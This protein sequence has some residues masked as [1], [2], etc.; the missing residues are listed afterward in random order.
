MKIDLAALFPFQEKAESY[1]VSYEGDFINGHRVTEAPEFSL[2]IT[3]HKDRMIEASGTGSV[4][5]LMQCSRCLTEVPWEIPFRIQRKADAET[6]LDDEGEEV[7]FFDDHTLDTDLLI[8]DE[9]LTDLP[10]KVLC[11]EDCKGICDR[12]GANLNLGPCGCS[13]EAAPTRMAEALQQAF[14]DAMKNA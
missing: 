8:A 9:V 5:L 3:H 2:L 6:C 4:T 14:R 7:W 1:T 10:V 11:K 12:C 13:R